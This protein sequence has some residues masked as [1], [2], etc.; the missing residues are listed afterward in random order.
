MRKLI[1]RRQF[2][3]FAS[4]GRRHFDLARAH[5]QAAAAELKNLLQISSNFAL[6]R[7]LS[8]NQGRE[9]ADNRNI[10]P[11]DSVVKDLTATGAM[12]ARL[13]QFGLAWRLHACRYLPGWVGYVGSHR[14]CTGS[15]RFKG[16]LH[17][18]I[19][20]SDMKDF[21]S[22]E[23]NGEGPRSKFEREDGQTDGQKWPKNLG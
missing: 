9:I 19:I 12:L 14:A 10:Y 7:S 23:S 17:S 20:S 18:Q 3:N 13:S 4:A 2:S 16:K 6:A 8:A 22:V 5:A 11:R 21:F 15:L 1:M